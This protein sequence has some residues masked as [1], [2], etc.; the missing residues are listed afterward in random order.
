MTGAHV[1]EG[2]GRFLVPGLIDMHTHVSK[3]RASGLAWL[4]AAGVTTVR[5]MGGDHDELL[6]WRS[7]IAAGQRVGPRLRIAGPYLESGHNAARQHATPVSEM[8]E[9]VE[10]TRLGVAT[11]ADA[12]R[13]VA[14]VAARGVDHLK[15]NQNDAGSRDVPGDR[16]C[17]TPSR[18]RAHRTRAAVSD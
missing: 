7:E 3:T 10:R 1:I 4:V 11:P 8:V 9:P 14:A 15:I 6:R 16:R 13:I 18:C 5:D 2:R 12:E 17:G